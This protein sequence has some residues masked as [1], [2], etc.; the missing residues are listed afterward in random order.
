M[1]DNAVDLS[2]SVAGLKHRPIGLGVAGFAEA[3][4]CL[5]LRADSMAAADFA[6]GSME[7]V[8]YFAILAS[9]QLAEER[10]RF[11]SYEG[12]KW[13]RGILPAD[14]LALL[15][16][17]RV[18]PL[19]VR[20]AAKQDWESVRARVREQGMRNGATTAV[21][22]LRGPCAVA[23]LSPATGAGDA[24]WL[25]ECAARRQKW[26]DLEHTLDLPLPEK[27]LGRLSHFYMEA[28]EKGLKTTRQLILIPRARSKE[29]VEAQPRSE[30]ALARV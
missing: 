23:A 10:G 4:G 5:G 24:Y 17:K 1:L 9:A 15:S 20:G 25:M 28:W 11:S 2:A 7:L 19:N 27:D 26:L 6:D 14:S 22:P 13:S 12:S 8:S 21:T 29:T 16:K 18:S 3:L 30:P